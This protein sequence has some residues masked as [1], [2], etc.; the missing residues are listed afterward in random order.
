MTRLE[1]RKLLET[2]NV[3]I[4]GAT[5]T[6]L[7]KRGMPAGVCPEKWIIDNPWAI[8][9]IQKAY[10][11]AGSDI[12]LAPTFTATPIKL[13]EYGLEKDLVE[14]N[15]KLVQLTRQVAGE[16]G[17]VAADISMTGKQLYP[18]GDLMFEDLVDCYK[19]QVKA[20]LEEGVD[21]FV[22]ET[23]MSLQECR[24]AVL[25]IKET[26]DLPI[27]V[28][29]TYNPDGKTLYGTSP[30]TAMIVLQSMGVDCVGMNCSTGPDAM[31]ELVQQMKKVA[32]VPIMVKPN[33]G[34]PELENGK[35]VYKMTPETF[36]EASLRLY[37]AGAGLFGGC[38]GSTPDHIKALVDTLKDKPVNKVE[39]KP[40]RVVTSERMN[41]WID[42]DGKFMVIGERINPT[43][44]KKFQETLREGSLSMVVDFAREQEEK[45]AN[46]LDVNM[47]M[48]GID[49][50]QMMIDSIYE[51]TSAVDLPL[52]LDTSHVEVMEA[53]LRIYPGRALINSISAEEE[54]MEAMLQLAKKYGAMFITLPLSGAGLPKDIEEKKQHINTV[55]SKAVE[56]GLKKEDAV[57][58]VLVQT[59]GA[60]GTA[61]LQCF[62]TI[63]YCK[64]ELGLPTVCGLSN[65]SFGM[66]NRQFVN[67]T[68][69]TIAVSKGL[70][71]AIANP[72]QEMLMYCAAAADTLMNK[73]GALEKYASLPVVEAKAAPAAGAAKASAPSGGLSVSNACDGVG[74]V[75]ECVIKGKKEQIVKEIQTMLD[76][77]VNPQ[78]IIEEH[79]IKGINVVGELYDKK[80]YFLPQLIAGANA[81]ELGMKHIE[82]LLASSDSEAKAKIV[83]ATVE[84]D[85][86]DIGKNLVALMLKNYGFEVID[87][88]KD[89]PAETI[90]DKAV[91]VDA[92]I[93][94][95]SALMTTTMM[96]MDDV[97]KL[98]KNKGCRAQIIIGGACI[99]E[100]FKDEINADGYSADAAEAVKLVQRLMKI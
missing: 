31:L 47:G 88:G 22:V 78:E 10:Y 23:M 4:D 6:E 82:P 2:R 94:G 48:N 64:Y 68:Y 29:L 26:C 1:F 32:T 100:S 28:S 62:E 39:D 17:L 85:I 54:K 52:C 98:A 38:C 15:H 49:E 93:I 72:N 14:I 87:L 91:E 44:K 95:L 12:V 42:L 79:L 36:A 96:R 24:A 43:G 45:G 71:M 80:K 76:A 92:D 46:I 99:N 9:E 19:A 41:T 65:I 84:G 37:E 51:V 90:I 30:D 74:P 56:L 25:A 67:T 33:A 27:I 50:K 60:E 81:M 11:D 89:V 40:L 75:A 63:E 35:T 58:D 86:H 77:G 16:T 18:L 73:E 55:L 21:L 70:T 34:L 61:A 69:L 59:V 57:V 3:F 7:Q 20:I 5:G 13:A 53:A 97:V 66:P 83:I 8:Q